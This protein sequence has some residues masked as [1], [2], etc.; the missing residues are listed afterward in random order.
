MLSKLYQPTRPRWG[1]WRGDAQQSLG[2]DIGQLTTKIVLAETNSRGELDY[3]TTCLSTW[4]PNSVTES[5]T[6]QD[7]IPACSWTSRALKSVTQQVGQIVAAHSRSRRL[8][9]GVTLGMSAC[10]YRTLY[11]PKNSHI[12]AAG[13][14]QSIAAAIGDKR[15]RCIATISHPE[16][17]ADNRQSKLRCL[18]LPEDLAWSIAQQLD[19]VGLMPHRLT[20]V[21]WCMARALQLVAKE[22][23]DAGHQL[24]IDWSYGPPTLVAVKQGHIDYVRCLSSGGLGQLCAQAMQRYQLSPAEACRWLTHCMHDES[25]TGSDAVMETRDWVREGCA[26]L[27]TEIGNSLEFIR[28]RNPEFELESLWLMGGAPRIAGLHTWLQSMV[29]CELRLWNLETQV[30]QLTS[31]YALATAVASMGLCHA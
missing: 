1:N 13:I 19:G 4:A 3:Q 27:A 2:I 15:P 9:I 20:C 29:P 21:P 14:Q 24:G 31:E 30:D 28:W 22:R 7:P 10:D 5:P 17:A 12:T 11:V 18:S 23:P 26:K 8:Q 25:S 16:S 6:N